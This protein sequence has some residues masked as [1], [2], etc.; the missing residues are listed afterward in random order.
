MNGVLILNWLLVH[1]RFKMT[2]YELYPSV[3]SISR[4]L[5]I[6]NPLLKGLSLEDTQRIVDHEPSPQTNS[7]LST[8]IY[9]EYKG[10]VFC[11]D[12]LT[13]DI[14]IYIFM[15]TKTHFVVSRTLD[16]SKFNSPHHPKKHLTRPIFYCLSFMEP[17]SIEALHAAQHSGAPT[18]TT[19]ERWRNWK[20][21]YQSEA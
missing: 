1:S 6:K 5:V 8:Y 11:N 21:C 18:M 9:M 2:M 16:E 7:W 10:L 15:H 12:H 13:Y 19:S 20:T 17:F 14:Y 3:I 4:W